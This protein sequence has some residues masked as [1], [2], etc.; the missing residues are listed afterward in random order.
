MR[1]VQEKFHEE[2]FRVHRFS[3]LACK[4]YVKSHAKLI[5]IFKNKFAL[6][7]LVKSLATAADMLARLKEEHQENPQMM[8]MNFKF[9]V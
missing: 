2:K 5:L 3:I 6:G 9:I 1:A 7:T 8:L 4:I